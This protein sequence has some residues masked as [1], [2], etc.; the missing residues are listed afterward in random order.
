MKYLGIIAALLTA[1]LVLTVPVYAQDGERKPLYA[2]DINE[3][4]YDIA[5]E[6][7]SSMFRVVECRLTVSDDEMTAVMTLSGKGYSMLFMGTGE[8]A[9]SANDSSFI[10]FAENSEGQYTYTVPVPALNAI[11]KCAAWSIKREQWYDRDLVFLSDSLPD[12][13]VKNSSGIIF[14]VIAVIIALMICAAVVITVKR[15]KKNDE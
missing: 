6:S 12:G 9:L 8:E 13:A 1:M 11:V 3:G 5:V 4:S 7:S 10:P 14:I 2:A 15:K